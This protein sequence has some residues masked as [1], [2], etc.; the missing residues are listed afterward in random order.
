MTNVQRCVQT[1]GA[2][3]PRANPMR[4]IMRLSVYVVGATESVVRDVCR[5]LAA[6]WASRTASRSCPMLLSAWA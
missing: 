6:G 3:M 5:Y 2:W 4:A 1:A